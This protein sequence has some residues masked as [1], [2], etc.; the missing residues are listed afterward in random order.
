MISKMLPTTSEAK[1]LRKRQE[2]RIKIYE[3]VARIEL[4]N[5]LARVP[6]SQVSTGFHE[7]L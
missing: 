5:S 2:Q 6:R 7:M 1:N 3:E 4:E